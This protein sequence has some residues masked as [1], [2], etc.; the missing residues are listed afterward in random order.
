MCT[1]ECLLIP[2]R[3]Y[4]RV[5]REE[6]IH[7]VSSMTASLSAFVFLRWGSQWTRSLLFWLG[8]LISKPQGSSCLPRAELTALALHYLPLTLYL[9]PGDLNSN[10]PACI[11]STWPIYA[12]PQPPSFPL[13]HF[14]GCKTN[15]PCDPTTVLFN[16]QQLWLPAQDMHKIRPSNILSRRWRRP[17][18]PTPP[19]GHLSS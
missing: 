14:L 1:S 15:L 9:G 7:W 13:T 11:A 8:W 4:K 18:R 2:A 6:D 16:E 17:M 3:V 19:S 10:G 12:S 5:G